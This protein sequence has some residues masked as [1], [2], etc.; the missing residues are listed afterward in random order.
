MATIEAK[1]DLVVNENV[2]SGRRR[3]TL[4]ARHRLDISV[5][6]VSIFELNE[7]WKLSVFSVFGW[8][9]LGFKNL[10]AQSTPCNF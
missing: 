5:S 3:T 6:K 4:A 9:G 2:D 10:T 1:M 7:E 8:V